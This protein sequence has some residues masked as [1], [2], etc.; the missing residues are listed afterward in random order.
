MNPCV[1]PILVTQLGKIPQSFSGLGPMEPHAAPALN[2]MNGKEEE[3]IDWDT[4]LALATR[5]APKKLIRFVTF[6]KSRSDWLHW[7]SRSLIG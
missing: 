1:F 2:K 5:A 6:C 3:G 7:F 4:P